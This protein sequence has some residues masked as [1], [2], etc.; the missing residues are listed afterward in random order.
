M[1]KDTDADRLMAGLSPLSFCGFIRDVFLYFWRDGCGDDG[2]GDF[3]LK[4]GSFQKLEKDEV[5][6][7]GNS[8]VRALV[9]SNTSSSIDE[10]F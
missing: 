4:Y 5:L 7:R 6:L 1:S 8:F 9:S 2:R 3:G 10:S